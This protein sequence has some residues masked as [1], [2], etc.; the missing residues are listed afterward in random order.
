MTREPDQRVRHRGRARHGSGAAAALRAQAKGAGD[1]LQR[2]VALLRA[3]TNFDFGPY[4]KSAL[5]RRVERRMQLARVRRLADYLKLLHTDNAEIDALFKDLRIGVTSF[6]RDPEAWQVLEREV[7]GPLLAAKPSEARVRIWVPGCATGEEAYSIAMVMIEQLQAACKRC[8]VQVFATDVDRAALRFA[9]NGVYPESIAAAVPPNRLRAFFTREEHSYRV[10]KKVREMVVFAEQNLITDPPFSQLD[11]IRCCNL[12]MYLEPTVQARIIPLL[13]YA[14]ADGGYVVFGRAESIRRP[15]LFSPVSKK[16]RIYRRIGPTRHMRPFFPMTSPGVG[17]PSPERAGAPVTGGDG[18][19]APV[20]R[21]IL[22]RFGPAAVLINRKHEILYFRGRT[23]RYLVQPAG[24]ATQNLLAK[25]RPGLQTPLRRALHAAIDTDQAVTIDARVKRRDVFHRVR[26]M[27]EPIARPKELEGLVLVSFHNP[28]APP[29]AAGGETP[30]VRRAVDQSVVDDLEHELNMARDELHATIEAYERS[31][32][33]LSIANEEIVSMNE[34]LQSTNEDLE[35]SKAELQALNE[36]LNILNGQ[37]AGKIAELRQANSDLQAEMAARTRAQRALQES[38]ERFR[39]LLHGVKDYA[40]VMLDAD[41]RVINWNAGAERIKGYTA[42]EIVG[43]H[44]STFYPREDVAA[45][46]PERALQLAVTNGRYEEEGWRVRKDGSRFLASV[47]IN[48]LRDE[49]GQL[50]GFAK[51]TRDITERK[52]AE[53]RLSEL[54]RRLLTSQEDERRR[55]GRELH[56]GVAQTLA[57]AAINLA[58]VQQAGQQLSAPGRSALVEGIAL[59]DRTSRDIR[60]VS[61]LLHP[62]LIEEAGLVSALRWYADGFGKRSGIAVNL[63]MPADMD[64]LPREMEAALFRIVQESLTNV[65]RHSASS[66]VDIQILRADGGVTLR[67]K[68]YG[69]GIANETLE[70]LG[71]SEAGVG[72]GIMGMRERAQLLGGRFDIESGVGGT[73]VVVTL[74]VPATPPPRAASA[75]E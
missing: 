49:S 23:D 7:L 60:T 36:E 66:T 18:V 17:N 57:A 43:K 59:V 2:I 63:D 46:R 8:D 45:G 27:I 10:A 14:L 73:A 37:L 48:S 41:G 25:A 42:D 4:K 67:V 29:A 38:E 62:P 47:I 40:I 61:Y 3:R 55:I 13:H 22:E 9:R 56:D 53:R 20:Q 69:Q 65:H 34:E 24:A 32:E 16:W 72:V 52:E 12:L 74:P 54:S 51:V 33:E 70:M 6:F 21:L 71:R 58:R 39:L 35:L 44:F 1:D 50:R 5:S 64:R 19:A 30:A 26:V 15:D 11:L 68:D 75:A 28:P 31:H